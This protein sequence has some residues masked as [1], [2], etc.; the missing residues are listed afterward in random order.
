MDIQHISSVPGQP[1]AG[2]VQAPSPPQDQPPPPPP[3]ETA[4]PPGLG[5]EVDIRV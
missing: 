2:A 3:A 1:P 4:N 5:E